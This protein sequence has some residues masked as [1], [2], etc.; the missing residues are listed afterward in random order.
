M[1]PAGNGTV[2]RQG[3]SRSRRS[4]KPQKTQR[5]K[6]DRRY[7]RPQRGRS[8]LRRLLRLF[9]L[10]FIV[11]QLIQML[12][13]QPFAVQSAAMLPT[14]APGERVLAL[15]A[16][17]GPL[18][19][20]LGYRLPGYTRPQRGD[21]VL[22]R[23]PYSRRLGLLRRGLDPV[24]RFFSAQRLSLTGSSEDVWDAQVVIK[25]LIGL[26]GDRIRF[27]QDR[28]YLVPGSAWG[29]SGFALEHAVVEREY[30]LRFDDP[31]ERLEADSP[32]AGSMSEIKLGDEEYFVVGDN[33]SRSLD[34]RHWGVVAFS[35]LRGRV[36]VRYLPLER[37][38]GL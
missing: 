33:R 24:L 9:V 15:P 37:F 20:G 31:P 8:P 16:A 22:V 3:F 27:E 2:M 10:L 29:G 7:Y 36:V 32:F 11:Y 14:L 17:Y 12:V 13:M 19:P 38:G 28:A 21:V 6:Q 26:P 35:A 1:T 25:R 4:R 5:Y 34:S 23:P 30:Q 18:V